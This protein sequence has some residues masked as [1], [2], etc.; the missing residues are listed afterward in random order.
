MISQ[1]NIEK[2]ETYDSPSPQVILIRGNRC[3]E[4]ISLPMLQQYYTNILRPNKDYAYFKLTY[5]DFP[6]ND[7]IT[8]MVG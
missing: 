7:S 6:I 3:V 2:N 4:T 1:A 5:F 8:K